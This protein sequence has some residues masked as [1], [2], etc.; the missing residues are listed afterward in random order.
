ML[1]LWLYRASC[2]GNWDKIQVTPDLRALTTWSPSLPGGLMTQRI[3]WCSHASV[4][5]GRCWRL[6][7]SQYLRVESIFFLVSWA[8]SPSTQLPSITLSSERSL[9]VREWFFPTLPWVSVIFF[10]WFWKQHLEIRF[11]FALGSLFLVSKQDFHPQI[12][13][14]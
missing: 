8:F 1:V 4:G 9:H 14:C 5:C 13:S 12:I 10:L 6:D 7:V 3:P 11:S 2:H